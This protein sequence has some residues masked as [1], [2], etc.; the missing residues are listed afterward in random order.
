MTPTIKTSR[1]LPVTTDESVLVSIREIITNAEGY[2]M[3]D[4]GEVVSDI[5]TEVLELIAEARPDFILMDYDFKGL[6]TLSLI[7]SVSAQFPEINIVVILSGEE[8]ARSNDVILAGARAFLLEPFASDDLLGT[9]RRV[10]ELVTRL[11]GGPTAALPLQPMLRSRGTITVFSPKGGVGCST[12]AIN[13]AVSMFEQLEKE[14]LLM[15]G[16]LLFGDLDVMLNLRTQNTLTDLISHVGALDEG[17]VRDVVSRHASGLLLLPSPLTVTSGQGIRPDALYHVLLELQAVFPYLVIDAGNFLNE[18]SVTY[19]DAS[20]RVLLVVNP[21]ISSL[22]DASQFFEVCRTLAYPAEKIKVV[23]NRYDKRDGLSLMD[24]EK[25]LQVEVLETIPWDRKT[26]L[27]SINR[28]VPV[29]LQRQNT[30]LR[31]AYQSLAEHVIKLLS[32]SPVSAQQPKTDVLS[33]SSRFG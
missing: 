13:L 14:V 27:Q 30:P 16:K 32:S 33:K 19:M 10:K 7:D 5:G 12:I 24:I 8:L 20:S 6:D 21:D 31:K 22:R 17:L 4:P 2:E 23:V 1:V 29:A 15:D 11:S 9:M 25:S 3:V 28:G 26:A 18:N